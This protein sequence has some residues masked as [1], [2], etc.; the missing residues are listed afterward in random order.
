MAR[1]EA[2]ALREQINAATNALATLRGE[3][4]NYLNLMNR[5]TYRTI[6]QTQRTRALAARTNFSTD[7]NNLRQV[8]VQQRGALPQAFDN[9]RTYSVAVRNALRA[10]LASLQ[11]M[12]AVATAARNEIRTAVQSLGKQSRR[13]RAQLP[14][15]PAAQVGPMRPPETIAQLNQRFNLT[16]YAFPVPFPFAEAEVLRRVRSALL[17][18]PMLRAGEAYFI[19]FDGVVAMTSN[20]NPRPFGFNRQSFGGLDPNN[21]TQPAGLFLSPADMVA[22]NLTTRLN[23]Y[24][25]AWWAALNQAITDLMNGDQYQ[26]QQLVLGNTFDTFNIIIKKLLPA[27]QGFVALAKEFPNRL[28][29]PKTHQTCLVDTLKHGIQVLLRGDNKGRLPAV[30]WPHYATIYKYIHD[31]TSKNKVISFFKPLTPKDIKYVFQAVG[32]TNPPQVVVWVFHGNDLVKHGRFPDNKVEGTETF[33]L[34]LAKG[35]YVWWCGPALHPNYKKDIT[36]DLFVYSD[37]EAPQHPDAL[38]LV[39]KSI[40]LAEPKYGLSQHL[41]FFDFETAPRLTDNRQMVYWAGWTQITRHLSFTFGGLIPEVVLPKTDKGLFDPSA[42]KGEERITDYYGADAMRCFLNDLKAIAIRQREAFIPRVAQCFYETFHKHLTHSDFS[43]DDDANIY[44][45]FKDH[46]AQ[47]IADDLVAQHRVVF[48]GYNNARFDNYLILGQGGSPY[49]NKRLIDAHGLI[50]Y[51]MFGGLIVFRDLYRHLS[52]S[53]ADACKSYSIPPHLSKGDAPHA[54]M[55]EDTLYHKGAVPA[56]KYW[57][58]GRIPADLEE[59]D[60]WDAEAYI[61]TYAK[62]DVFATM[63]VAVAY[64]DAMEQTT[65]FNALAKLTIPSVAWSVFGKA[66]LDADDPSKSKVKVIKSVEVDKFIRQAILGGRCVKTKS[67]YRTPQEALLREVEALCPTLEDD[68]FPDLPEWNERLYQV[69]E[70]HRGFPDKVVAGKVKEAFA[71]FL[72]ENPDLNARITRA[73]EVFAALHTTKD[74]LEDQDAN[75][76]Y[77]TAMAQFEFSVEDAVWASPE[78]FPAI[79]HAIETD[80][81]DNIAIVE[82]EITYPNKENCYFPVMATRGDGVN[83]YTL[84]DQCVHRHSTDLSEAC[85]HNG[86]RITAIKRCLLWRSK[87]RIF[88][89]VVEKFYALRNQYKK[90]GKEALQQVIKLLLNSAYG[91]LIQR[92]IDTEKVFYTE[93]DLAELDKVFRHGDYLNHT[94]FSNRLLVEQSKT[95][96]DKDIIMPSHL[97]VSVLAYSRKVM[98]R[99]VEAIGG[100]SSLEN[101]PYYMDTDSMFINARLVRKME[102]RGLIGNDLGQFKSDLKGVSDGMIVEAIFVAPKLYYL[103]YV[104]LTPYGL[105][106]VAVAKRSKGT[107]TEPLKREHYLKMLDGEEHE[108]AD[109]FQMK[110]RLD[111]EEGT[112]IF[113]TTLT[114]T[115]NRE[116][117][118]GKCSVPHDTYHSVW[119]PHHSFQSV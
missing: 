13:E 97:G 42:V 111:G 87:E 56:A 88:Q 82:C 92:V 53:L 107:S 58:G 109:Q 102:E 66:L 114:K 84:E 43:Y 6:N 49:S 23:A 62:R 59:C 76:L 69:K 31:H 89:A 16:T 37:E 34:I 25:A 115:L 112:G 22:A 104:G 32:I 11:R 15:L 105:P 70:A 45:T 48:M 79:I 50:E 85:K 10:Q 110:R 108:V 41:Y 80:T 7:Y 77:P 2:Q 98:N 51:Q 65:G 95:P 28:W 4:T 24:V 35:H 93:D 57:K 71:E 99:A 18:L 67:Y 12:V 64:Y 21:T 103:R 116:P 40:H 94:E 5:D 74:Y 39:Q 83:R 101:T 75:S 78:E 81:F 119:L 46:R 20:G 90:E 91:K 113:N 117:W 17:R 72:R 27:G 8:L 73:K 36:P 33:H 118:K 52:C 61:R 30:A 44:P 60:H 29:S 100:F 38:P 14:P 55:R 1:A 96:K 9:P 86:M 47:S 54:F 106:V 3:T 63:L 26:D 19:A 68:E